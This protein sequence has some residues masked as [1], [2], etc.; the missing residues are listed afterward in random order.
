VQHALS[1]TVRRCRRA[2]G[3]HRCATVFRPPSSRQPS[4]L[5]LAFGHR[6]RVHGLLTTTQGHPLSSAAVGIALVD[7]V[8]GAT[9]RSI[10]VHTNQQGQFS[11]VLPA[12]PSRAVSFAYPGGSHLQPTDRRLR[13]LT[14]GK[15]TLAARPRS[16]R[17][18]GQVRLSGRVYGAP[19]PGAGKLVS[20]QA[21]SA[22]R[23]QTFATVHS[24]ARGVY[25]YLKAITAGAP[26][27]YRLRAVLPREAAYPYA[28]GQSRVRLVR[29]R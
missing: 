22:H 19:L 18:P 9:P 28:G 8:R 27:V 24:D 1:A 17:E 26:G 7:E 2:S 6:R 12:G 25:S 5:R 13:A 23:W 15:V 29:V 3:H 16:V 11:Y 10:T 21:W 14:L 4:A 20:L